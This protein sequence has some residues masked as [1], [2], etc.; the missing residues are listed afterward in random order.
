MIT[1]SVESF[2]RAIPEIRA[3]IGAHWQ[4]LA[5]HKE[6]MP[7]D[8]QWDEYVKREREGRLFLVTVR[9]DGE[10]IAYY[11][12]QVAPGFHY[13]STLTATMDIAYVKEEVRHKGYVVPLFRRVEQELKRRGVKLWYSG[14]KAHNPLGMDKV[15]NALGF[16]PADVYCC[17]WIGP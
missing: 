3:I 17:K 1:A 6:K 5:L 10:I 2:E 9:K 13:R 16:A 8:P 7:L 15:L 11:I 12:A 14:F 4:E